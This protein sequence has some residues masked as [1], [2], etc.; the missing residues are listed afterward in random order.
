MHRLYLKIY[1]AVLASLVLF[2]LLVGLT[3]KLIKWGEPS[4]AGHQIESVVTELAGEVLPADISEARLQTLLNRWHERFDAD[5]AS[6]F[7]RSGKICAIVGDGLDGG[8]GQAQAL[9]RSGKDPEN[10]LRTD[11]A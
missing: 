5:L 8:A 3:L 1:L 10:A 11:V 2:V 6:N 7:D 9:A 4:A